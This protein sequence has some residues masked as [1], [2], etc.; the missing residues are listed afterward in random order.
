MSEDKKYRVG[1]GRPPK[2]TQFKKGRSGNPR[3]RP[4][5]PVAALIPRQMTKDILRVMELPLSVKMPGGDKVL[6]VREA[7]I[8]S[9]AKRAIGSEKV[10]YMRMWLELQKGALQEN[11]DTYPELRS[12]ELFDA[13]LRVGSVDPD[14]AIEQSLKALLRKS[15]GK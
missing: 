6:T 11:L 15:R 7:C 3:G 8:Y 2:H 4:R 9:V 5:K 13:M 1:R 12:I 14:G 10:A